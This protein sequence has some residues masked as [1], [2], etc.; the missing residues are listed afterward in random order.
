MSALRCPCGG[1]TLATDQQR[2]DQQRTDQQRAVSGF[3]QLYDATPY[4][5]QVKKAA[6]HV[7]L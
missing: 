1:G 4:E 2:T 7:V 3:L 5:S 6:Q